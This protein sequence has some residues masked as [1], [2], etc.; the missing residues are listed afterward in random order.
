L[1]EGVEKGITSNGDL[2]ISTSTGKEIISIG[3]I[4]QVI[5]LED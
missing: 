4:E 3:E 1:I 2:I 5:G